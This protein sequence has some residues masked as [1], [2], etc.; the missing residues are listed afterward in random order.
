MFK[1]SSTITINFF[2]KT[3]NTVRKFLITMLSYM[4]QI[5]GVTIIVL[6]ALLIIIAA[7]LITLIKNAQEKYN[8]NTTGVNQYVHS[9]TSQGKKDKEFYS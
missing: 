5:V 8:N 2:K 6:I 3:L 9:E 1:K 4:L 7:I